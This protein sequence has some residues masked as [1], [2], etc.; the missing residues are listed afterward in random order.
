MRLFRMVL[1]DRER[2]TNRRG[3]AFMWQSLV[4]AAAAMILV[5]LV[6]CGGEAAP[7]TFPARNGLIA[8]HAASLSVDGAEAKSALAHPDH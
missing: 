5:G 7:A 1:G 4:A 2:A 6:G 3:K 8:F